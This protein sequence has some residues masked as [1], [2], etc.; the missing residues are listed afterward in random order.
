MY[1]VL[2]AEARYERH[3]ACIPPALLRLSSLIRPAYERG[4]EKKKGCMFAPHYII[5]LR[6]GQPEICTTTGSVSL[7]VKVKRK[8]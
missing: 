4:G 5:M 2:R 6:D 7:A 3:V 8:I 1:S